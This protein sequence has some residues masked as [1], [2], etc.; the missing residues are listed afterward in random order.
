MAD[1]TDRSGTR[2]A[3]ALLGVLGGAAVVVGSTLT[4]AKIGLSASGQ[5]QS[6]S[7]L[8]LQI[9]GGVTLALGVALAAVGA[10]LWAG[11]PAR[12]GGALLGV[13][14][15]GAAYPAAWLAITR[16]DFFAGLVSQGQGVQVDVSLGAGALLVLGG[17]VVGIVGA[18]AAL[19]ASSAPYEPGEDELSMEEPIEDEPI[20]GGPIE[21]GPAQTQGA[22]SDLPEGPPPPSSL[23]P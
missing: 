2:T 12:H 14:A 8:G 6:Q 19:V 7:V 9:G 17:G 21:T 18:I 20:E 4:W 1:T 16:E 5:S 10:L 22:P 13:I 3:A 23:E 11:L 15:I